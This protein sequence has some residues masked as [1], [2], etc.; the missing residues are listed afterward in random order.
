MSD[1]FEWDAGKY[2]LN[3]PQIDEDHQEIIQAMND[4][5]RLHE[6]KAGRAPLAKALDRLRAVTVA[7]FK[8]EEAYMGKIGYA[9][10]RK[11]RHVHQH[12]LDRLEGFAVEFQSKGELTQELFLF[13]KM[14][15][16]SHICGIDV[17]YAKQVSAA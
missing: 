1:F 11:H 16:K 14:W 17:Q 4:L 7:H 3:I 9:D 6:S 13:L 15:L 5:H 8:D 10:L 2:G 12:L